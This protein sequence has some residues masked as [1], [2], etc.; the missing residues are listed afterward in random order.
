MRS[1]KII[2]TLSR[3]FLRRYLR[4]KTA[5]F[6]TFVFPVV[7][8]V[9]FGLLNRNSS[10]SFSVAI[11]NNSETAVA[12]TFVEAAENGDVL[13]KVDVRNF[14][15]A[16]ERLSRGELDAI[17]ELSP[18]FGAPDSKGRP[19]GS[20]VTYIDQGDQQLAQSLNAVT[21]SIVD[22]LNAPYVQQDVPFRIEERKLE[23][24]NLSAFDYVFAGLLG[25]A[26]ISL[27]IFGMANGF[28]S[29]KKLG[30]YR[31]MRVAP[32]KA[33]HLIVATGLMYA[34]IGLLVTVMMYVLAVVALDFTMRGNLALFLAF[35]TL[36]TVCLYGFGIAIAGWARNENQAAPIANLVAFPMMFLSGTFFPR[37]LMPEWL[38]NLTFFLPLTPIVD[39]LRKIT[40][41]NAGLLQL[42][43]ELAVIS[44]WTL[45]IYL[46]AFKTFRWE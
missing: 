26:L 45:V 23:T 9:V 3:F 16:K 46:V 21:Q 2:R 28:A 11:I 22:G 40:T 6:F 30:A 4:D 19:S 43:S 1:L 25:F 10:P 27:G 17:L 41:E 31:R 13:E 18:G 20:L 39:G 38:Q 32:I 5:L 34:A 29:D 12:R 7:F 35:A 37:F 14:D 8:L 33:W 36:S 15:D 42:G 24:A 44:V